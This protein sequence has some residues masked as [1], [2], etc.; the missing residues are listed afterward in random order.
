MNNRDETRLMIQAARLYYTAGLNQQEIA[1]RMK[2]TRQKI[3]RLLESARDK[4]I[5]RISIY[6]PF[7]DDPGLKEDLRK[8]YNLDDVI[9][10]SGEGSD[11]STLR[12][13]LGMK[14]AE[15]LH[16]NLE[17]GSVIGMGWG[18]T[19][20]EVANSLPRDKKFPVHIIPLIG[21]IGD[22]SPFF[23]VNELARRFAEVFGGT[24]RNIYAPA[25]TP[26]ATILE[27][28]HKTQ[29]V[30]QLN[31]LWDHLELAIIGIGHV[32]FQQISSM[33]FAEHIS[34]H[35]LAQLE[36]KGAVGDICGRFFDI[37]GLPVEV[38]AGVIG[39]TLEQLKSIPKVIAIAGGLEKTRALL[40]A[41][42][43]GFIKILVT[44]IST[45]RA[46]LDEFEMKGGDSDDPGN[47]RSTGQPG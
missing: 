38:S 40:G 3:A 26:D 25:F 45:A 27:S 19:L 9:L 42:R 23:Q 20:F 4:G 44:D 7:P 12:S 31:E 1:G 10:V 8:A 34:P 33:F 16:D 41:L 29:E 36:A 18:R 11:S 13:Q 46:I 14:A 37:A 17:S 32:E 28:L 5:V 6:D 2:L 47:R 21:G 15:Y 30:T 35:M 22:M 39:I 43:G 24:F